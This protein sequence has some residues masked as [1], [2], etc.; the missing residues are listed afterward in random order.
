VIEPLWSNWSGSATSRPRWR[1]RASDESE[2]AAAVLRARGDGVSLRTVGAGHS[3]IPLAA[4]DGGLLQLADRDAASCI[5]SVD[6]AAQRARVWA[7]STLNTLGAALHEHGLAFHNLGDVDVQTLGGAIGTGTHGTGRALANLSSAVLGVRGVGAD[8]AVFEWKA[9][10]ADAPLAAAQVSL[11][12]LGVVCSVDLQLRSSLCLHER[13]ERLAV[14]TALAELDERAATARH[15]EFFWYPARDRLDLKTLVETD[16]PPDALPEERYEQ[17]DWSHRILPSVRADRFVEMEYA[18]PEEMGIATFEAVRARMRA[19]HPDVHWPVEFRF[20]AADSAWLSPA[21]GRATATISLHQDA[22]LPFREFF[23]DVEP[24]LLEAGGRPHWGK[25][26]SLTADELRG[27]YPRWEA[28]STLR[29][30]CDPEGRFLNPYLREL[31]GVA[32]PDAL[33]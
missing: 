10:A 19:R 17:I 26:H 16:F 3:Q 7:G 20:V 24:L 6:T 9:G 27:L 32:A 14:A 1:A 31:L 23:A 33:D 25:W 22:R 11:G 29:G 28:F 5:E 30:E 2:V 13:T 18:L 4:A 15:V 8:G 12:A 21:S